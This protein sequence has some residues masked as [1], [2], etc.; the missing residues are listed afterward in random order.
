MTDSRVRPRPIVRVLLSL[1]L[2]TFGSLTPSHAVTFTINDPVEF[3]KI[4]ST[5]APHTTNANINFWLEGSVWMPQNGGYL[6]F[7]ANNALKKLVP[8]NTLTDLCVSPPV[9]SKFNGNTLDLQERLVSCQYE[10]SARQVL[11]LNTTNCSVTSL[12]NLYNTKQFNSPNDVVVKSDGSIWFTD[13]D[14][15]T[16]GMNNQPGRYVYRFYPTNGNATVLPVVTNMNRPNGLCFSPDEK[17]LYVADTAITPGVIKVFNVTSSN[18]VTGGTNFCTVTAGVSDGLR[19]DVDGRVWTSAGQGVEIY[20]SDGHLIGKINFNLV[21]NLCFGGPQYKTL[22]MVGQP[23]VSSIPVLVPGVPSMKR[24]SSTRT[25][26]GLNISWPAPSTG[27]VLQETA[28]PGTGAVWANVSQSP[29]VSNGS[30]IVSVTATNEQRS[31]R[32]RLN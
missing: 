9:N 28:Q 7:T 27:Y 18:T 23:Y 21:A 22:Y 4:I 15:N 30:N 25:G 20:A 13:P 1:G 17:R 19:C 10:G 8:P 32:L 12:V 29:A 14:Y 16:G 31:Y 3:H 2:A 6:I 5:N 11:T 26:S 24:L